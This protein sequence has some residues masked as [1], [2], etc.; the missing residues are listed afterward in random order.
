MP[1]IRFKEAL[2]AFLDLNETEEQY[3]TV[4]ATTYF[5]QEPEIIALICAAFPDE[6]HDA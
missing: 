4:M 5:Y 1:Y 6:P 2:I 3:N